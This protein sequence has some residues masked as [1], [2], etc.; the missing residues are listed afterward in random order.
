M[1]IAI[2]DDDYSVCNF[3]ED[4]IQ[5]LKQKDIEF[6]VFTS[7]NDLL[8]YLE[9]NDTSYQIYFMDIEMG[10]HNGI[11][12][13]ALIRKRDRNAL[14][15]FMTQ[16]KEYVYKV[17]EV[18]PFRFLVKPVCTENLTAVFNDALRHLQ[19]IKQIFTFTQDRSTIQVF[20]DEIMYL[21]SVGRKINIVTTSKSYL[22]YGKLYEA[23][24]RLDKILFVQIHASF[25]VNMEYITVIK[26]SEII[27][28]NNVTLTIS[29]K[30]RNEVKEQY[31]KYLEWRCGK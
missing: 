17:F 27:M 25:I 29:K 22:I 21:E 26:D 16:H 24:N 8:R 20:L 30:Y 23:Y 5:N 28:K 6:D 12:T 14:I 11:E 2:C 3:I 18:L 7:G 1:R 9:N 13:A 15:I 19:T 10:G 31:F 4:Y